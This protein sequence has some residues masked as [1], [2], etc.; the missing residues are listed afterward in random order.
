[1]QSIK[2]IMTA[3]A[4][5]MGI[6]SFAAIPAAFAGEQP[7]VMIMGEDADKDTVP[8][9]SRVF[10]RVVDALA[11]EL[12]NEGFDVYD[13]V[14]LTMDDFAQGRTRR[15]DVEIIDIARSVKTAPIDVATIFAIYPKIKKT[16][17]TTKVEARI[18]GRLLNVK[19]GQRLGNF[20]VMSAMPDNAPVECDRECILEVFGDNAKILAQDLGVVLATKL[21]AQS[22]V[23]G[24]A[25]MGT[26]EGGMSMAYSLTFSGFSPDEITSIEE[27]IVAFS[28]YHHHRPL[29]SS[30]RTNEYWYE[31][32]SESARLNRNL[33]RMMDHLGVQGRVVFAGN[34]FSV[35]K[36][37]TVRKQR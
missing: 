18:T 14:S 10:K 7:N 13:E 12:H 35:E 6:S 11:N 3:G 9:N 28:G 32:N 23:S 15:T 5:A 34:K 27:Y 16:A 37:A 30:M 22:P 25:A 2:A 20:E 8:R 26:G 36:I 1:M 17:Y 24:G 31:T 4:I 29:S 33:R 21:D 19:S